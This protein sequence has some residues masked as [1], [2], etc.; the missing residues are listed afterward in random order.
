MTRFRIEPAYVDDVL[1]MLADAEIV[2]SRDDGVVAIEIGE[3]SDDKAGA[4]LAAF[5]PE[6]SA[7]IGLV[8]GHPPLKG[9]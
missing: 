9:H 5:R 1:A 2:P 4:I 8:G 3:I 7:I 6:W